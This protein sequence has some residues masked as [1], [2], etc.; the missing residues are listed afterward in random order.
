MADAITFERRG[1][2][3]AIAAIDK[4]VRTTGRAMARAHGMPDYPIAVIPTDFSAIDSADEEQV[5][6]MG[7]RV[8]EQV[9]AILLGKF[10]EQKEAILASKKV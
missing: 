6:A 9:E 10:A 2:P 7:K 3:A 5:A 8:A 1:T 4:L